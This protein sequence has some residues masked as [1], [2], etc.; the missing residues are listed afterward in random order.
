[1]VDLQLTPGLIEAYIAGSD[2]YHATIIVG[3]LP[4]KQWQAI[5]ADCAGGIESLLE[6]LRGKIDKAIMQRLCRQGDGLFPT[7]QQLHLSCSCPDG[8][9][10]CK[11]IAAVLYAVG[12]RLDAQPELL[13]SLRDV[14]MDE[15]IA[16][17][18]SGL[19]A[20][21]ASDDEGALAGDDL[22]D[23][24]GIELDDAAASPVSGKQ[25]A[26]RSSKAGRSLKAAQKQ[27]QQK[28]KKKMKKST[29]KPAR[30]S[31]S[32]DPYARLYRHLA[33]AGRLTSAEA[34]G[35]LH[36]SAAELRPLFKRLVAEGKVTI[37]GKARGTTYH[38]QSD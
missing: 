3:S 29:R 22:G 33:K 16:S 13:F 28:K 34:Q 37:T 1:V 23:I 35:I 5:C 2:V 14:K 9:S 30:P 15:L 21:P 19:K 25:K 18:G 24:F 7:P 4:R 26:G 20:T 31:R 11:H 10:M 32:R 6:L 12:H 36:L 27:K 38:M 17:A 8:A